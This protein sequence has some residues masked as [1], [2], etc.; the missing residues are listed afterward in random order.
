MELYPYKKLIDKGLN[1]V[2]VAH[3]NIPELT[4]NDGLPTTLSSKV[5]QDQLKEKLGFSGLIISDAM[6]MKGVTNYEGDQ[7][8]IVK[9]FQAGNDILLIPDDLPKNFNQIKAAIKSGV[10]AKER[11]DY[12]VRKILFAK[13]KVGLSD[14][15]PTKTLNL[16]ADINSAYNQ[17]L[18]YKAFSSAATLIKNDLGTIPYQSVQVKTALI[19]LGDGNASEFKAEFKKYDAIDF[20]TKEEIVKNIKQISQYDRLIISHH[21]DTSSPWNDYE[22]SDSDKQ[23]IGQLSNETSVVLVN[24][25]SPYALSDLESTLSIDAILIFIKI[26]R[27]LK[28]LLPVLFMELDKQR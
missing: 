19:T 20:I 23:L 11:L 17:V 1:A 10:I 7:P 28:R 21:Q 4:E 14:Y 26:I 12:S 8:S 5:I 3:L 15:Q 13:Y 2:M 25:T 16:T 24:F 27:L 6:N 18:A 9:A 22:I